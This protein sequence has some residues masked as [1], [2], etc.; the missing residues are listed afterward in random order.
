MWRLTWEYVSPKK[1]RDSQE[2][3]LAR[4]MLSEQATPNLGGALVKQ[5]SES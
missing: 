5:L 2:K 1:S 4:S 3:L